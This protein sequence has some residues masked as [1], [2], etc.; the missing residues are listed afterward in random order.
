MIAALQNIGTRQ[1]LLNLKSKM[2]KGLGVFAL[3]TMV[4]FP[5]MADISGV[6]DLVSD[7]PSG[8]HGILVTR[9][10]SPFGPFVTN[11]YQILTQTTTR[12][13]DGMS[14]CGRTGSPLCPE[15]VFQ[16]KTFTALGSQVVVSASGLLGASIKKG[17]QVCGGLYLSFFDVDN[18]LITKKELGRVCST[19]TPSVIV[20]NRS[21]VSRTF[22]LPLTQGSDYRVRAS[23][24]C[25]YG[26][27]TFGTPVLNPSPATM[28]RYHCE[29][30]PV[31]VHMVFHNPS[32]PQGVGEPSVELVVDP[33]ITPSEPGE[34]MFY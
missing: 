10:P 9:S 26:N 31:A 32:A 5:A 8:K 28:G 29:A 25:S 24:I 20:G 3:F 7:L 21:S 19:A 17:N 15:S 12:L 14:W 33:P 16:S 30:F 22:S 4:A 2:R 1:N 6:I 18:Q 23:V 11:R 34:F 27:L 13:P